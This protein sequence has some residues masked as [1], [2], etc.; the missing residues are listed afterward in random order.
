VSKTID[1]YCQLGENTSYNGMGYMKDFV[2]AFKKKQS[3]DHS[4]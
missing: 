2:Q 3:I 1:E 4:T